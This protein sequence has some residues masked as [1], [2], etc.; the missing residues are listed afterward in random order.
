MVA[1]LLLGTV[2]GALTLS[3]CTSG[4][5]IVIVTERSITLL[6]SMVHRNTRGAEL[7]KSLPSEEEEEEESI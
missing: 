5:T 2:W 4:V 6:S 7:E 3:T 1:I